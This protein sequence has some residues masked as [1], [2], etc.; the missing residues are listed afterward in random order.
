MRVE[1]DPQ[2]NQSETAWFPVFAE[3][4]SERRQPPCATMQDRLGEFIIERVNAGSKSLY[5]DALAWLDRLLIVYV[6]RRTQ[7]NQTQAAEIL[8]I[9]RGSL[10]FKIRERGI[11]IGQ[12]VALNDDTDQT[13][14]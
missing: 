1:G 13:T 5:A 11:R 4:R 6:L 8:G 2:A 3:G 7:G 10:R 12:I 9:T 14:G